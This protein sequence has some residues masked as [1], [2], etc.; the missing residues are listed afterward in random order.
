MFGNQLA[1]RGDSAPLPESVLWW[2]SERFVTEAD[3]QEALSALELSIL[4]NV[5]RKLQRGEEMGQED[6]LDSTGDAV[7]SVT[8]EVRGVGGVKLWR[9]ASG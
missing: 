7:N 5:S 6:V 8:P 9:E 3:L 4:Q 1:A 2:L